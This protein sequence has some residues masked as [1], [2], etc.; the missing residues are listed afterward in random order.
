MQTQRGLSEA[1]HVASKLISS[2]TLLLS[3]TTKISLYFAVWGWGGGMG[4]CGK[5]RI[6]IQPKKP[7]LLILTNSE[8]VLLRPD[9]DLKS[10]SPV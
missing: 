10:A 8:P 2:D 7:S 6:I 4:A 3:P 5:R 1:S 9:I